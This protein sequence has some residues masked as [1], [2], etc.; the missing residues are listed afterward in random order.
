[1]KL[2]N[3]GGGASIEF[4]IVLPILLLLMAAFFDFGIAFY[5]KQV[6]TNASRE[7]ARAGIVNL[8]DDDGNKEEVNIIAVVETYCD[9]LRNDE[10]A[11]L[12]ITAPGPEAL[13]LLTYP[14]D[15]T[16]RVT[17]NDYR[18][19][20]S[21]LLGFFGGNFDTFDISAVTVMRME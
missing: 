15:L 6:L 16:V 10:T 5:N 21:P 14:T 9:S 18:P 7:G 17:L 12:N 13:T 1:M 3:H 4:I 11:T 8:K 19:I 2:R 20:L